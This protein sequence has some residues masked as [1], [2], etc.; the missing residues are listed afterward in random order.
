[1]DRRLKALSRSIEMIEGVLNYAYE[2]YVLVDA[3]GR[4]V[5]IQYEKLLGISQEE[6]LGRP[7]DEVIEN[8]RM[9]IVVRTGVEE[10]RHVQRIQGHDMITNR[11]PIVL[12]GEVIGGLGTVLFKDIDEL[13]ELARNL[14]DLQSKINKYRFELERIEGVEHSFDNILTKNSKMNYLKNIGKKAAETNSTVLIT[15]ESGTGKELFAEAIHQASYRKDGPFIAINCGAIPK[16]L[17]EA[18]LF[19]YVE[20]AFTGA[21]QRGK[22]GKF[23]IASG[24][25]LFLDEIGNMPL[26]MQVKLL[27]VLEAKVFEPIGSNEKIELDARIIAA[28]NDNLEEEMEKGNFRE[29]LYYRLNVISIDIPPLRER[30]E[31]IEPIAEAMLDRLSKEMDLDKKILT[32]ESKEILRGYDWPGNV[33]ELRNILERAINLSSQEYITPKDISERILYKTNNEKFLSLGVG[34]KS[35]EE[36]VE[37]TERQAIIA[38]LELCRGNRTEAAKVL[39]IHRTSLYRRIEKYG[40]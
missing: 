6:A 3:R 31:D 1:M 2:G 28:T 4:V 35:L 30:P 5:M 36:I 23:K 34:T 8:T 9:H 38:A 33:R 17:I 32:G 24:G 40:I 16:G 21:S 7:V 11:I 20:G 25:T 15:G 27:R 39:G 37:E 14:L 13:R 12:D 29:D 18:E 22:D 26:D 19:G 10:L